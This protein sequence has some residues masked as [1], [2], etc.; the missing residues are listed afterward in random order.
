MVFFHMAALNSTLIPSPLINPKKMCFSNL[1]VVTPGKNNNFSHFSTGH[2]KH[3]E[4]LDPY[5]YMSNQLITISNKLKDNKYCILPFDTH[6]Q[7]RRT[8][9]KQVQSKKIQQQIPAQAKN[10][11]HKEPNTNK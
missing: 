8:G 11:E 4:T 5:H 1:I 10:G 6:K 7:N 2:S 9:T 3:K